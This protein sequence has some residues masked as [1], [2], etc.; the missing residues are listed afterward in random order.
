MRSDAETPRIESPRDAH[1]ELVR[2]KPEPA[3]GSFI[4]VLAPGRTHCPVIGHVRSMRITLDARDRIVYTWQA[5]LGLALPV[6]TPEGALTQL[7][8]AAEALLHS[9]DQVPDLT[10]LAEALRALGRGM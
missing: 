7:V 5:C 3:Q 6:N 2:L 4:A 9:P 8:D 1:G 10:A